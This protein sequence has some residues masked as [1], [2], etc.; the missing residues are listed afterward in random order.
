[1]YRN[2]VCEHYKFIEQ[3]LI[4]NYQLG[5]VLVRRTPAE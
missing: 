5:A 2:T 3:V 4:I 1:M